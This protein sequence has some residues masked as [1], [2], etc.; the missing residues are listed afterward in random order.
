MK[1]YIV[2]SGCPRSG[3]SITSKMVRSAIGKDRWFGEKFLRKKPPMEIQEKNKKEQRKHDPV[4]Q[5]FYERN[6]KL[7][8]EGGPERAKRTEKRRAKMEQMNPTGFYECPWTVPGIK[9]STKWHNKLHGDGPRQGVKIVCTGLAVSDPMYVDSVI[10]CLRNPRQVAKSQEQLSGRFGP[11]DNPSVNK[12][13]AVVHSPS[14]FIN[15]MCMAARWFLINPGVSVHIVLYDEI[16]SNPK[17]VVEDLEAFVGEGDWSKAE[18]FVDPSLYRSKPDASVTHELWGTADRIYELVKEKKWADVITEEKTMKE[19]KRKRKEETGFLFCPRTHERMTKVECD[20]CR[21]NP[22]V[23]PRYIQHVE[24]VRRGR[25]KWENEP[26]LRDV[27]EGK[28]T[29]EESMRNHSWM[30]WMK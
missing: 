16:H 30:E 9:Y 13:E 8:K 1:K 21:T 6:E 7:K 4:A 15:N 25:V 20:C 18:E 3:T 22:K 12:K 14:T 19:H 24:S 11:F 27:Q 5:Y 28:C 10:F 29:A 23:P 2:V 26:C 17:K